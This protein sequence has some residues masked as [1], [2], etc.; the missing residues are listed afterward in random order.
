MSSKV[1]PP[2]V[3]NAMRNEKGLT[4]PRTLHS[5]GVMVQMFQGPIP[6]AS[7]S[8]WA[9]ASKSRTRRTGVIGCCNCFGHSPSVRRFKCL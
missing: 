9:V 8:R 3:A 7:E 2:T 5:A 4:W 1:P 6:T